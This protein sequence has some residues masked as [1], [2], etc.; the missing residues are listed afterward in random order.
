MHDGGFVNLP[1][2]TLADKQLRQKYRKNPIIGVNSIHHVKEVVDSLFSPTAGSS[3][4][5]SEM[6]PLDLPKVRK[7][8]SVEIIPISLGCNGAC[9]FCQT[10]LA[11]GALRSYPVEEVVRRVAAVKDSASEIWLTSE[12]TGAYGQDIGSSLA[13]LLERVRRTVEDSDTMVKIGMTNPP[14]LK[15]ILPQLAETLASP[16]FFSYLHIPV[17][18]VVSGACEA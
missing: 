4:T 12:D 3:S 16:H 11:R 14:Y 6:P 8:P 1:A 15:P 18:V 13:A 2:S 17:Q 7:D 5:L 9:T 10:K